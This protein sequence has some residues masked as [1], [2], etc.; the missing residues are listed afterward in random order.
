MTT[1]IAN[2]A[3]SLSPEE[4]DRL[5]SRIRPSWEL[6]DGESAEGGDP[7]LES[8]AHG[9]VAPEVTQESAPLS[10]PT[11]PHDTIIDGTPTLDGR[12][13]ETSASDTQDA[14][15]SRPRVTAQQ[16]AGATR[17]GL[18]E[19]SVDEAAKSQA[20]V[21]SRIVSIGETAPAA[22]APERR[23][24]SA[25]PSR[26]APSTESA[27]VA[28][29]LAS[30]AASVAPSSPPAEAFAPVAPEQPSFSRVDDPIEIP[31]QKTSR[32]VVFAIGGAVAL[33][34]VLGGVAMFSGGDTNKAAAT[35]TSEPAKDA[36]K[37]AE[38][39]K[40]LETD[41]PAETAKVSET[42][43]AP[44]PEPTVA[45]TTPEP[46]PTSAPTSS[47]VA[48]APK[49]AKP[50]PAKPEPSKPKPSTGS[51]GTPSPSSAKKPPKGGGGI[52]R[53]APF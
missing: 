11:S 1:N 10:A 7:G 48:P 28:A 19:Q 31:V 6:D 3:E 49:P 32:T 38:T 33:A 43:A 53:D 25:A 12:T 51:G 41:K 18:G 29:P 27:L 44:T 46:A 24:D 15:A 13:V 39:A 42:A 50:E 34:A 14:P 52:I 20:V 40:P 4:A 26:P 45:S 30:S 36:P 5:A 9:G 23:T 2:P 17:V 47:A 8:L 22:P 37:A 21:S 16:A 35:Q